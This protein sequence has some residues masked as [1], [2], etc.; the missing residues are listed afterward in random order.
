M[1]AP[2]SLKQA[3]IR[4]PLT[5]GTLCVLLL[6]AASA[7]ASVGVPATIAGRP[8]PTSQ[9]LQGIAR[10]ARDAA[11]LPLHECIER[12]EAPLWR[13]DQEAMRRFAP[14]APPRAEAERRALAE[15]LIA[16]L[17][18]NP[19]DEAAIAAYLAEHASEWKTPQRLRVFRILVATREQAVQLIAELADKSI[20]DFRAAARTHSLDRSSHERGGDLGF[21]A[22]DGTTDVPTVNV[23]PALFAAALQVEE[24]AFVPV[25]VAEGP[26]FAVVWRRGSQPARQLDAPEAR[27][28]AVSRLREQEAERKL[29]LLLAAQPAERHPELLTRLSR[30][31]C[32][33]FRP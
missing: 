21:V 13:L 1:T 32:A 17:L 6:L 19:E 23:E 27:A 15:R 4:S 29:E 30:S 5:G 18:E 8:V 14:E 12:F 31:E 33:L 28:W 20:A 3:R 7:V 10:C 24:G 16:Q 2:L 25:P 9:L 22:A 26:H 11:D